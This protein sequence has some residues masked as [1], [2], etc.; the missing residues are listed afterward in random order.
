MNLSDLHCTGYDA[1]A[2]GLTADEIADLLAQLPAWSL[3]QETTPRLERVFGF[4]TFLQALDF[5]LRRR[6][7]DADVSLDALDE[8]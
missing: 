7:P 4:D 5:V 3:V 6:R 1:T 2:R 8:E